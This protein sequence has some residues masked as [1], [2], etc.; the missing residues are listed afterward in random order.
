MNSVV[1]VLA[2]L[3]S[4]AAAAARLP[5]WRIPESRPFTVGLA[6]LAAWALLR[7]PALIGSAN[8]MALPSG[9]FERFPGLIADMSLVGA[10]ALIGVTVANA[11]GRALLERAFYLGLIA[12]EAA[13]LLTYDPLHPSYVTAQSHNWI[14][15]L[16]GV[17]VNGVVVAASVLSYRTVP[18][19]F[20]LPL[21][22]FM[23]GGLSGVAVAA[24]RIITL[25][26]PEGPQV[27]AW[28]PIVSIPVFGFALGSLVAS[29]RMRK[30]AREDT[31]R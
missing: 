2:A 9:H 5:R 16:A 13:L 20:R 19:G 1:T 3:C 22:L 17:A 18:P 11:W 4:L 28:S 10:G 21:A 6:L 30:Q 31:L 26:R 7:T 14:L 25:L 12:L 15:A 27:N 23:F 8:E 24:V 29:R